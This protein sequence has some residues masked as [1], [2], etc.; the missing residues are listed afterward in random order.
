VRT[1]TRTSDK[2]FAPSRGMMGSRV[3]EN[4][5]GTKGPL[6]RPSGPFRRR[7]RWGV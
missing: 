4:E 1:G 2:R 7:L 5:A 6:T 3:Q